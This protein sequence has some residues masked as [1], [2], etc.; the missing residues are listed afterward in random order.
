MI[1]WRALFGVAFSLI[2]FAMGVAAAQEQPR[3][4]KRQPGST[5]SGQSKEAKKPVRKRVVTDLSGFDLL[6]PNKVRRQ[7]MVVGATRGLPSPVALAPRLGKLHGLNPVFAWSFEGKGRSF[8]FVLRDD[9]QQE[10]FRTEVTGN[11]Y[12]YPDNAPAL[13]PEKT[14]FW[15]I[16]ASSPLLGSS[17]SG[18]VGF[19]VVSGAQREE[20][21]KKLA[22]LEGDETL[23][24]GLVR[25]QVFTDHRLWYDALAAYADL[26]SH[27]P[28]RPELYE[29]R[30]MIYAQLDATAKLADLDFAK[31]EEL[32]HGK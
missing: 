7:T 24:A 31:A 14:Y 22:Q 11:T 12:R 30:G 19:I 4:P 18:P 27:F 9:A 17:A 5:V 20:I 1:P 29:Q 26:I 21:E 2:G 16:E 6:E 8:A 25:A 10:I 23:Q 3:A 15:T 28:D 32:E 13:Q